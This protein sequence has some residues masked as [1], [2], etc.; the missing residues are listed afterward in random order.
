MRL[1]KTRSEIGD[2]FDFVDPSMDRSGSVRSEIIESI[3]A[4][5]LSAE[6][7]RF[8]NLLAY[9]EAEVS[10]EPAL[11]SRRTRPSASVFSDG[12]IVCSANYSR[13]G[14]ASGIRELPITARGI[15]GSVS[16]SGLQFVATSS[17][18]YRRRGD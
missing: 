13:E 4:T 7:R 10:D 1:A 12:T 18:P 6:K 8:S 2:H 17:V 3:V 14:L 11:F 5:A 16:A 9:I 15:Y